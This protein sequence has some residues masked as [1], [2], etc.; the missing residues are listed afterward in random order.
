MTCIYNLIQ[1]VTKVYRCILKQIYFNLRP[2][3]NG[4]GA[5]SAP[6]DTKMELNF[7]VNVSWRKA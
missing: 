4:S 7:P 2:I 5:A 3:A 6:Q 1:I